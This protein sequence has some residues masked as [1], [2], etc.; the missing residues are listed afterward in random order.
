MKLCSHL[1]KPRWTKQSITYYQKNETHF[2]AVLHLDVMFDSGGVP[3]DHYFIQFHDTE[4]EVT[5]P[6][7]TID[8][9]YNESVY[10]ILLAQNCAGYSNYVITPVQYNSGKEIAYC[11][12]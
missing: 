12:H 6:T 3:I 7:Y 4:L 5:E 2:T 1:D 11:V 8:I 10:V 9:N